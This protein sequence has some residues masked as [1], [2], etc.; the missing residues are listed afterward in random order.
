MKGTSVRPKITV[1][2]PTRER[3]DVLESAL[4]TVVGQD[5]EN[6]EILVSDNFSGDATEDVT[7]QWND[8]RVRYI[9]TGRRLSMTA[10]WE[11]ALEHVTG[12]WV[13]I[14]GDDDG[15]LPNAI[16]R[17]ADFIKSGGVQAFQSTTCKYRWPG[18]KGRQFGQIR[19]PLTQGEEIRESIPWMKKVLEGRTV[20]ADLPMLYTGGFVSME[21]LHDLRRRT[22]SFYRSRIPDVYSGFAIASLISRYGFVNTP[23]CISGISRHSIGVDQFAMRKKETASPSRKFLSEENLPFHKDLPLTGSG[24]IPSS[25]QAVVYE[26]CLQTKD[27][28]HGTLDDSYGKQLEIILACSPEGDRVVAAWSYKFAEMHGLDYEAARARARWRRRRYKLAEIPA[29]FLRRVR[30]RRLGSMKQK[31]ENVHEAS[32]AAD[33]LLRRKGLR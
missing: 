9:N 6:L 7:R 21:V 3:C 25:L 11:F 29:N 28:R 20:Y 32:L 10:N 5:Y 18:N 15:L 23:L 19:V 12:G 13:T 4:K 24:D 33:A 16:H 2:I 17:A 14:V 22:G 1:V 8:P 27:L 31:L 30:R 26:S